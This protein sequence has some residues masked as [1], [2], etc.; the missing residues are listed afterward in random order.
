MIMRPISR[1]QG[2][3]LLGLV[4]FNLY[5]RNARACM[6]NC[7][8]C[9][10]GEGQCLECNAG[11]VNSRL[12]TECLSCPP[13]CQD[14]KR[15]VGADNP[16][17]VVCKPGYT[18]SFWGTCC[19]PHCDTC[20]MYGGCATCSAGYY[21]R[22][23]DPFDCLPCT[24]CQPGQVTTRACGNNLNTECS[25]CSDGEIPAVG[26]LTCRA[27]DPG[28]YKAAD[29]I[30]CATCTTCSLLQ[31][32][33]PEDV[34]TTKKNTICTDCTGNKA[35]R[36]LNSVT[37]DTCAA[38][39]YGLGVPLVC[40]QCTANPCNAGFY[41]D[42][43]NAQR[44]CNP[45]AGLTLALA[46]PAGQGP[47]PSTCPAGTTVATQSAC[48]P[49]PAGS[50]RAVAGSPLYCA[51]CGTGFYKDA[52]GLASCGRC[53]NAPANNSLYMIWGNKDATTASCPW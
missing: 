53:A 39:Y 44:T 23:T 52:R 30:T 31:Y 15:D 28:T 34:C 25:T 36:V 35:V 22:T 40:Y 47:E 5:H 7:K 1:R 45:C 13:N 49:C 29:K 18:L 4:V 32:V 17:C 42:C 33:K 19:G 26:G 16:Y 3:L 6:A 20:N 2:H 10:G 12:L 51:K 8:L 9:P 50:E 41:Q 38:G 48:T 14:C 27:C 24:G 21:R 43:S 37:C 11:Y 46:C